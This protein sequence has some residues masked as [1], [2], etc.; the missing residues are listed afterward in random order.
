MRGSPCRA[1]YTYTC[2]YVATSR[3]RMPPAQ[4]GTFDLA[5]TTP[6]QCYD[7]LMIVSPRPGWHSH[8][9]P[10]PV[11]IGPGPDHWYPN[12]NGSDIPPIRSNP[13]D[14][15]QPPCPPF[16]RRPYS[17]PFQLHGRKD[18]PARPV[19]HERQTGNDAPYPSVGV[20]ASTLTYQASS[21]ITCI[22]LYSTADTDGSNHR[23]CM[24]MS[25]FFSSPPPRPWPLFSLWIGADL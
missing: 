25:C 15:L 5:R 18:Q 24:G 14:E 7:V 2:T 20:R 10:S 22:G 8:P 13:H 1:W 21:L 12:P 4:L 17:P 11:D 9:S 19:R 16:Q 23:C 3:L 6:W